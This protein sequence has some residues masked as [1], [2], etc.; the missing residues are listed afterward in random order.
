MRERARA[1]ECRGTS[2]R[3]CVGGPVRVRERER[4]EECRGTSERERESRSV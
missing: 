4:A 2:E 1:E 3:E